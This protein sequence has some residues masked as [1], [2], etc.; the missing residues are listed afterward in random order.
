MYILDFSV[1]FLNPLPFCIYVTMN[2]IGILGN[3]SG[4]IEMQVDPEKEI[5]S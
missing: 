3:N 5:P 1:V 4:P 2:M